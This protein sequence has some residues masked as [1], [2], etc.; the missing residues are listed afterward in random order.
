[1][2]NK[3]TTSELYPR[4]MRSLRRP[5]T[6][7][8]LLPVIALSA[9]GGGGNS[10]DAKKTV[11]RAFKAPIQSANVKLSVKA[12]LDGVAALS[13]PVQF[14]LKGPYKSN[15]SNKLPEFDWDLN[16]SGGGQSFAAGIISSGDNAYVTFGGQDY[17]VGAA[18]VAA[19]N[20]QL[21]ANKSKQKNQSFSAF[22]V[23]PT[24]WLK[25]PS[26]EGTENVAGVE[27]NH[28]SA[29]V[30]MAKL[31]ADLNSVVDKAPAAGAGGPKPPKLT[32]AQIKQIQDVVKDPHFD[33]YAGKDDGKLR[34][35]QTAF[36]FSVPDSAK[37]RAGGLSG[38]KI[39]F[40]L[41]FSDVGKPQTITAPQ[42][43]KPLTDLTSQLRGLLGGAGAG[44]LGLG[45]AGGGTSGG[46]SGG[47]ATPPAGGS[48]S[49]G[50]SS[51][52]FKKYSDCVQKAPSS[53]VQAI[54]KCSDLLQ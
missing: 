48:P 22:G 46:T 11:D 19:F 3:G 12:E 52:S 18:Q 9:C 26:D 27:T 14:E 45:G 28:V 10:G 17:Q 35:V 5:L 44:G 43:A 42:N 16:V 39:T 13:K 50:A 51:D 34:K 24:S 25:D 15:G 53:D 21:Q 7:V 31:L 20:K 41:E 33:V 29:G 1:M 47:S 4:G 23:D 49:P 6:A 36:D 37:A 54:Q 32:D 38:G 8:L 40:D 30:D 2:Y